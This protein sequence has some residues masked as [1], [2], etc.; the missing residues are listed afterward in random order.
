MVTDISAFYMVIAKGNDNAKYFLHK[1]GKRFNLY[2]DLISCGSCQ[3]V[4][5]KR[6]KSA[7]VAANK[8]KAR[9]SNLLSKVCVMK[10]TKQTDEEV[11]SVNIN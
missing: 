1:D 11:F 10:Y 3:Y 2:P 6:L 9:Y 4:V 8:V 7:M 5:Y